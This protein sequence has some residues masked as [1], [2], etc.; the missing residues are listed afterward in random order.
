MQALSTE[1]HHLHNQLA[2]TKQALADAESTI[3]KMEARLAQ[4]VAAQSKRRLAG[5]LYIVHIHVHVPHMHS[6]YRGYLHTS[7]FSYLLLQPSLWLL[8]SG[9]SSQFLL[10]FPIQPAFNVSSGWQY[11]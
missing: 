6:I 3:Q 4:Q 7:Q 5:A 11:L 9:L 10:S 8:V 1:N 2:S